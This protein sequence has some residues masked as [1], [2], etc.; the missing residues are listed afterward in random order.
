MF[1]GK[2]TEL[3][4]RIACARD[5]GSRVLAVKPAR[6]TRYAEHEIVTHGGIR[7]PARAVESLDELVAD[8]SASDFDLIA[9]DEVH[10]FASDAVAPIAALRARGISVAVAG[11]DIDHFGDVFAPFDAL[12]PIATE[13]ARIHGTCHRCGAPST[14][15]ERL[16]ATTDR[17]IV[18]GTKEFIA[19]CAK[20]FRP[21]TR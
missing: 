18:G 4:R 17:I 21:S 9:I 6:D 20:C 2:T 11:C 15:S 16:V 5:D 10:F 7:V 3:Q 19:T 8:P 1:A 14:H 13:V 12:L